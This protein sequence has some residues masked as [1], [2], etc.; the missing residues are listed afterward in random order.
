MASV[1]LNQE[2]KTVDVYYGINTSNKELV[3]QN[4][5]SGITFEDSF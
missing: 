5:P 4:E 2:M 1:S 3:N